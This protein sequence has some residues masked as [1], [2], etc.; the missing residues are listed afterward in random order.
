MVPSFYLNITDWNNLICCQLKFPE[1]EFFFLFSSLLLSSLLFSSL[2]V[3]SLLFSSL[4]RDNV[5]HN[6]LS[7][8][9][10][11]YLLLLQWW[12]INRHVSINE[13]CLFTPGLIGGIQNSKEHFSFDWMPLYTCLQG[14][15]V[16]N[17]SWLIIMMFNQICREKTGSFCVVHP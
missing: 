17:K 8:V 1:W 15:F 7:S 14:W 10:C 4:S 2:L 12:T 6:L 16:Q 5:F 11:M 13:L 3:S 9:L